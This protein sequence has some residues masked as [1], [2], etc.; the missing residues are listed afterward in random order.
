MQDDAIDEHIRAAVRPG[1]ESG[2]LIVEMVHDCWPHGID[3]HT[4]PVARGWLRMWGPAKTLV[5]V[6]ICTCENGHCRICN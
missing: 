6:P 3:D 4:D 2:R 1:A 5:V